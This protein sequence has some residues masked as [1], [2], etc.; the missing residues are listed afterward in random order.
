MINIGFT[1]TILLGIFIIFGVSILFFLRTIKYDLSRDIDLFFST[2]GLIYS[3]ILILHG[4]RLDPILFFGQILLIIILF[5]I[6]RHQIFLKFKKSLILLY[7]FFL[8][9][10][11]FFQSMLNFYFPIIVKLIFLFVKIVQPMRCSL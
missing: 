8:R 9:K 5:G 6:L 11:I 1:P 3:F 2:L 7:I 10:D 4:W